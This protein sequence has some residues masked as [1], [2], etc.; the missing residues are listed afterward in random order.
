MSER[1]SE[2]AKAKLP[3]RSVILL[4]IGIAAGLLMIFMGNLPQKKSPSPAP[5]ETEMTDSYIRTLESRLTLILEAMDG[6][7]E[8]KV[9]ITPESTVQTLYATDLRYD[10]GALTS[11]EYVMSDEEG[12]PVIL[13]LVY[14]K[15]RGVAVVCRGGGD[16][17]RAQKMIDLISALLDLRSSSVC[18]VS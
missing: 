3:S 13:S 2:G 14:P 5:S 10:G 18:V 9:I 17:V 15:I 7:S 1:N 16:P 12:M 4:I 11:K 8:V 6:I